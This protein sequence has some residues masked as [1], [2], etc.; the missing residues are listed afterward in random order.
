MSFDVVPHMVSCSHDFLAHSA[1]EFHCPIVVFF[2]GHHTIDY[3]IQVYEE[4][5][6]QNKDLLCILYLYNIKEE[7]NVCGAYNY[8]FSKHCWWCTLSCKSHTPTTRQDGFPGVFSC[9][10][11]LPSAFHRSH[12]G[13]LQSRQPTLLTSC[14]R[15]QQSGLRKNVVIPSLQS[16]I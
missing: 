7:V 6:N 5:Q 16:R 11:S 9:P 1:S 10:S 8:V 3:S 15:A 12:I 13:T 4:K 2:L 14:C